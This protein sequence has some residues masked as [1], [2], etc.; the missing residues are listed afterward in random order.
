MLGKGRRRGC[1]GE[2][3]GRKEGGT[4]GETMRVGKVLQEDREEVQED[5]K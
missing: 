4:E 2:M 5:G 3:K 1:R